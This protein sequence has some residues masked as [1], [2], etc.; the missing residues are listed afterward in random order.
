M[1]TVA[2][3]IQKILA[4]L[5]SIYANI[6][7]SSTSGEATM[8]AYMP[9]HAHYLGKKGKNSV[10]KINKEKKFKKNSSIKVHT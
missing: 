10:K 9:G 2:S 7:D 6:Y 1:L 8:Y 4:I 5:W 3:N